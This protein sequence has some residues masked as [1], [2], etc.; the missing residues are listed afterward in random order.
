MLRFNL[1]VFNLLLLVLL[2]FGQDQNSSPYTRFG[3]GEQVNF[4]STPYIGLGG[5]SIA[6]AD[7]KHINFSNP[8]TYSNTKRYSPVFDAGIMG[9]SS[10]LKSESGNYSQTTVSL[11]D[12]S[13]LLPISPKTGIA[14]GLM[15]FSTT[16]YNISK[17]ELLNDDTV[18]QNYSGM[19]SVNRLF[20][21]IGQQIINKGDSVRLSVGVNASFL[22]GTLQRDRRTIFDDIS[23]YNSH[24]ENKLI[25]RGFT[26]DYGI[27][28]YEKINKKYS[29]QLGLTANVGNNITAYQDFF[30]YTYKTVQSTQS[31]VIKDTTSY[32]QDKKGFVYLPKSI[33]IG[34]ALSV[35]KK[36]TLSAQYNI[37]DGYKYYESFD[38]VETTYSELAQ[39][40]KFSFGVRF[41]PYTQENIQNLSALKLSS[42]QFGFHYGYS[43]Y[44]S[45]EI[46]LKEYGIAFGISM[47][48]LSSGSTSS[49]SLGIELGKLGTTQNGLIEDN[50]LKFNIGLSL[51]PNS[52]FD[53]WFW[54]RLYD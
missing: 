10:W 1:L 9:K 28:Y 32:Y 42:Y 44:K 8:A 36:L 23:Y 18:T 46:H 45:S 50:Y 51:S 35:N 13:L 20:F 16:G 22:F 47:P 31:E 11:R 25:V 34:G 15:P 33:G 41:I 54:K 24:I 37:A 52:R 4:I 49:M 29:F 2:N 40:R 19:G 3:L 7:F 5:A 43:P 6:I 14:F 48:L 12:F 26:M 17:Y 39:M 30:A 21:G 53:K 38:S 27:H